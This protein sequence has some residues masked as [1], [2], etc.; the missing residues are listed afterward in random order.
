MP[1][2]HNGTEQDESEPVMRYRTTMQQKVFHLF[3]SE[4]DSFSMGL[5]ISGYLLSHVKVRRTRRQGSTCVPSLHN[6]YTV[7]GLYD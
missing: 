3:L 5:L 1:C 2:R 7:V 6:P 4:A